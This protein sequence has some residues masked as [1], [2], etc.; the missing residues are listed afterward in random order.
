MSSKAVKPRRRKF[1]PGEGFL[2]D[3][4]DLKKAEVLNGGTHLVVYPDLQSIPRGELQL[5]MFEV[6]RTEEFTENAMLEIGHL[7]LSPRSG[8]CCPTQRVVLQSTVPEF[9]GRRYWF[10][11]PGVDI[12]NPCLRRVRQLYL[13][14]GEK[15]QWAC[16]RCHNISTRKQKPVEGLTPNLR[17][18]AHAIGKEKLFACNE[19]KSLAKNLR[20]RHAGNLQEVMAEPMSSAEKKFWITAMS[21]GTDA[22]HVNAVVAVEIF[23][24]LKPAIIRDDDFAVVK[25]CVFGDFGET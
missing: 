11:C 7:A 25:Q 24:Q 23:E 16:M 6:K 17:A 3:A 19:V 2:L 10:L 9:G 13:P 15:A 8:N 12:T 1:V 21:D 18:V 5:F 22:G 4:V 20:V 14:A